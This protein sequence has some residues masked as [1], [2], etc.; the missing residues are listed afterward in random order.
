MALAEAVDLIFDLM[1][2][3]M[4][5]NP[6]NA[7]TGGLLG[8]Y[9][10]IETAKKAWDLGDKVGDKVYSEYLLRTQKDL[11]DSDQNI[12][13]LIVKHNKYAPE[14]EKLNRKEI[15]ENCMV[16]K[17]AAVDTSR[18]SVQFML[19]HF[20]NFPET[21]QE[22]K[23]RVCDA[24]EVKD[25]ASYET[26]ERNE[27]LQNFTKEVVRLYVPTIL[28]GDRIAQTD[29]KIGRY[30]IH[31]GTKFTYPIGAIQQSGKFFKKPLTFCFDRYSK[32]Q[33]DRE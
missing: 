1:T 25:L 2:K 32:D 5:E 11:S 23:Q 12:L 19:N 30:K 18:S 4:L 31:K 6:L 26:Y 17:L 28:I 20:V 22:F 15:I 21:L 13:D 9:K 16:M 29:F 3:S 27:T 14:S 10:L 8:K 7:F 24:I 33:E